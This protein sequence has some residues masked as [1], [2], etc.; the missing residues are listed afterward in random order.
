MSLFLCANWKSSMTHRR[1]LL[2]PWRTVQQSSVVSYDATTGIATF[3]WRGNSP[4]TVTFTD[5]NN[6]V[7]GPFP[8]TGTTADIGTG[9]TG[10][11]LPTSQAENSSNDLD[12]I[13]GAI[14]ILGI[15]EPAYELA[16]E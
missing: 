1:R 5:Q 11:W 16:Y 14:V 7:I 4:A 6:N 8:V 12:K 13:N 2:R 10:T 15:Y 9:L 3:V